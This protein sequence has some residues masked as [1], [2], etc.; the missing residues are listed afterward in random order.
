[1]QKSFFLYIVH[2]NIAFGDCVSVGGFQYSLIFVDRT[3]RYNWVFGLKDLS[4][5]S[6][7]SAFYLFR[8]DAGSYARCFRCDCDHKLFGTTI[9]E[10][11]IN[12]NS[13]IIVA[14]AGCQSSNGLV[15]ALENHGSHGLC[16]PYQEANALVLLVLCGGSLRPNDECHS[17]QA[18]WQAGFSVSTR[19]R[20]GA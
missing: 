7:L 14:A 13:N 10:H 4:K 11:L 19:T 3:T 20:C 15:D 16:L 2:V 9:W 18:L 12:N 5:E 17:G 1:L 8:A 6:I